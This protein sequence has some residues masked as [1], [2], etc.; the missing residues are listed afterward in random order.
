M[1]DTGAHEIGQTRY[2]VFKER[3]Y[4]ETN[5]DPSF[6]LAMQR[7]CPRTG[8]DANL[9]PLDST[10]PTVFYNAFFG[11]LVNRRGLLHSDQQIYGGGS[12]NAQVDRYRL[13]SAAF[14]TDF[15]NAMVKMGNLSPLTGTNGQIRT[16]CRKPN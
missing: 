15:A 5:I 13:N 1:C 6:A 3:I 9:A 14:F 16:N 11:N 7:N 2:G 4:N 8:G 12:T 10:T